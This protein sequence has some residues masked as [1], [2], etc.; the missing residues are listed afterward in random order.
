MLSLFITQKNVNP[1]FIDGRSNF[2]KMAVR[3]CSI[4]DTH[5]E[6]IRLQKESIVNAFDKKVNKKITPTDPTKIGD[7][8]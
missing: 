7:S 1:S 2:S 6:D 8:L 5:G 4:S 3:D